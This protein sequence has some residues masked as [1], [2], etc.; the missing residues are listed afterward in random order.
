MWSLQFPKQGNLA[1][2]TKCDKYENSKHMEHFPVTRHIYQVGFTL[3]SGVTA[4]LQSHY[5]VIRQSSR[6]LGKM[7]NNPHRLAV[8][9]I[10]PPS[11]K[12]VSLHTV[13]CM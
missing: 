10:S 4:L 7:R 11:F 3:F 1:E 13:K 9:F 12:L 6:C 2:I 5:E 8:S